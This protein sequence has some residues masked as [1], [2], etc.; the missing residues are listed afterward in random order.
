M[1]KLL[2]IHA[3]NKEGKIMQ[4]TNEATR[5]KNFVITPKNEAAMKQCYRDMY[6]R[7]QIPSE[8][9]KMVEKKNYVKGVVIG[10]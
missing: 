1:D 2:K 5:R 8:L 9:Y 3:N 6:A 10:Q 7:G 4:I